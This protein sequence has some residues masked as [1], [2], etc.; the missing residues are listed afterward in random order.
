MANKIK[1]GLSHVYYAKATIDPSTGTATYLTPVALPGAVSL[2]MDPSGDSN[3]FYADNVPYVTFSANA[4]YEG[5]LEVALIPDTFR[6]TILGEVEVSNILYEKAEATTTPFALLF[7]FEG[8]E[9]ATRHVFYNCTASRP[10]VSSQTTEESVDVQ[11]ESLNITVGAIYNP[12]VDANVAKG[13]C[14]DD[15]KPEYQNWFT[16]VQ[17]ASSGGQTT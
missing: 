12:V 13:R 7:Q 5:T 1:F 4:G 17:Q 15:T 10:N 11:T 6:Q 9:K 14:S 3:K 8:D 16:S 2:S